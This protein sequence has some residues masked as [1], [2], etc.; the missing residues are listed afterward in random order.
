MSILER[1]LTT[2]HGLPL[3][4]LWRAIR[5]ARK[6]RFGLVFLLLS[7]P[8][9]VA[10]T[11]YL[12]FRAPSPPKFPKPPKKSRSKD[13][14]AER[15]IARYPELITA[16]Y[17]QRTA[18]N[19]FDIK[20]R[21][22]SS[23]S[24]DE[25][26]EGRETLSPEDKGGEGRWRSS[27]MKPRRMA[28]FWDYENCS[29]PFKFSKLKVAECIKRL[30]SI[31]ETKKQEVTIQTVRLYQDLTLKME[32]N[33]P[34]GRWKDRK[35]MLADCGV[36]LIHA[37]HR[38]RKEVVDNHII[39]DMFSWAI[40]H[41][42]SVIT[43]IS[44]DG[45]FAL[46]LQRL[47]ARGYGI[48]VIQPDRA[49]Q[50]LAVHAHN[51]FNWSDIIQ[52]SKIPIEKK[53]IPTEKKKFSTEKKKI[54]EDKKKL[55]ADKKKIPTEKEK[56][57][58]DKKKLQA[59]KKKLQAGQKKL[60]ADKKKLQADKKKLQAGKKKIQ[61]LKRK[62]PAG[63]RKL[64]AEKKKTPTRMKKLARNV[65]PSIMRKKTR[66]KKRRPRN[67]TSSSKSTP[68]PIG[69]EDPVGSE[70]PMGSEDLVGF[71]DFVGLEDPVG[72]E[73]F[74]VGSEEHLGSELLVGSEIPVD[75]L[76]SGFMDRIGENSYP[77]L[78][79]QADGAGGSLGSVGS[80]GFDV[81]RLDGG[82]RETKRGG[83][84]ILF[85]L[86]VGL[87][88]LA[89]LLWKIFRDPEM[90]RFDDFL[91]HYP[92]TAMINHSFNR[93]SNK[94]NLI[95]NKLK[96]YG[97]AGYRSRCLVHAKHALYHL[98]Y[99][100]T[101]CYRI[102]FETAFTSRHFTIF[103]FGCG[104]ATRAKLEPLFTFCCECLG[105]IDLG[106]RLSGMFT[107]ICPAICP[108]SQ[109]DMFGA[110]RVVKVFLS[111]MSSAMMLS[112]LMRA[113]RG[114]GSMGIRHGART[115]FRSYRTTRA[116]ASQA[117]SR[118]SG[119]ISTEELNKM[120]KSASTRIIDASWHMPATGRVGYEEYLK[121]PRVP[122]AVFFDI[123]RASDDSNPLPHMLPSATDF[124]DYVNEIGINDNDTVIVYD[125]IG[126]FS[127]PR[128]WW[129]FRYF[130]HPNVYVLNGGLPAWIESGNIT[131]FYPIGLR[132]GHM[133][134]AVN[135]PFNL[136][137]DS[138]GKLLPNSKLSSVF[139]S[140]DMEKGVVSSC[141]SG[142]TACIVALV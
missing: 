41:P 114:E 115:G 125:T 23:F 124:A 142:V 17:P 68:R 132:S 107:C 20:Y 129:M 54:Q 44:G 28:V 76:G 97:A 134:N 12:T 16:T 2:G 109:K 66:A 35:E 81:S 105:L 56:I 101:L 65:S 25:R 77:T 50:S 21:K 45:D 103:Q 31:F 84:W 86:V 69:S 93:I 112:I 126:M 46:G 53:K 8:A 102:I 137:L 108:I 13:W 120:A 100:P 94:K 26:I 117:P 96:N 136:V 14:E 135:I 29:L 47:R 130:Q 7:C 9:L 55:Q 141:G 90:L 111:S 88:P 122:N 70:D 121:G 98:S 67:S 36:T 89:L 60:Q 64:P 87:F 5:L 106:Y 119:V 19:S 72:Y 22:T 75:S 4:A 11:I 110:L 52:V 138:N 15:I 57:Q 59:D 139:A 131:Q 99:S 79:P 133:P 58:E 128:V 39:A 51:V 80:V 78:T 38:K 116:F 42:G 43:L 113:A 91:S 27:S 127:A 1:R 62:F 40:D 82:R 123:D 6:S 73:D 85:A 10:L 30:R 118:Q 71:E 74:S 34:K 61:A 95:R 140:V 24:Q 18:D 63:K 32:K 92:A 33:E 37:S 104:P 3:G 49:S 83:F 48:I